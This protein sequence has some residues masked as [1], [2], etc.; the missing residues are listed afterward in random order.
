MSQLADET[1]EQF[2]TRLDQMAGNCDMRSELIQDCLVIRIRNQQLSEQLQMEPESTLAKAEKLIHQRAAIGQQQ[3][4]LMRA[5]AET[6]L[7]LES[8]SREPRVP[9]PNRRSS[10]QDARANLVNVQKLTCVRDVENS[11]PI[12]QCP[13]CDAQCQTCKRTGH[14]ITKCLSKTVAKVTMQMETLTTTESDH[15]D[16]TLTLTPFF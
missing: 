11:H 14:Y 1:V 10:Q 3:Q 9:H 16:D 2:I 12:Q 15:P 6:K 8:M 5:P 4:R 7:Q 13:A